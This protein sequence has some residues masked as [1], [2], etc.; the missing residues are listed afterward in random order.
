MIGAIIFFIAISGLVAFAYLI[1][2][3]LFYGAKKMKRRK[4]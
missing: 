2:P 1:S 4:T 3:K